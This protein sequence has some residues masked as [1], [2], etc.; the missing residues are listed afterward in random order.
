VSEPR[1]IRIVASAAR[2]IAEAAAWWTAN[3]PKAPQA[4]VEEL[5]RSLRLIALQPG[6]G[7]Q[8]ANAKLLG[9][10][11]I[12]LARVRYHLYYRVSKTT[13]EFIEVLAVWHANRLP[14]S[15]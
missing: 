8:A 5:E 9:V 1:E 14:P 7:A 2:G 13:P 3:R 11:R 6:V 12:H 15:I 10:R 4:F